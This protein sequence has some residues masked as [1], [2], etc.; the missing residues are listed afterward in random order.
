[1]AHYARGHRDLAKHTESGGVTS[2]REGGGDLLANRSDGL[3]DSPLTD[4]RGRFK[5]SDKLAALSQFAPLFVSI[6]LNSII[7][8]SCNIC[9]LVGIRRFG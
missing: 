3:T 4:I 6:L 5:K 8:A 7:E 1:M 2:G 9:G